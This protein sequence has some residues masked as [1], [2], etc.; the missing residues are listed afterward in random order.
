MQGQNCELSNSQL[1]RKYIDRLDRQL[2]SAHRLHRSHIN[3]TK[4]L[5]LSNSFSTTYVP[6]GSSLDLNQLYT[7]QWQGGQFK[8]KFIVYWWKVTENIESPPRSCTGDVVVRQ[9]HCNISIY[10]ISEENIQKILQCNYNIAVE[11]LIKQ[12]IYF[13]L[14]ISPYIIRY[15]AAQCNIDALQI[16]YTQSIGE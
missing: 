10:C 1:V 3:I 11:H 15:I 2:T 9:T 12:R 13:R 5:S 14:S 16:Q 4:A 6:C 7:L 8:F